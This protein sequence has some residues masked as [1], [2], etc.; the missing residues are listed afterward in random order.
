MVRGHEGLVLTHTPRSQATSQLLAA[1]EIYERKFRLRFETLTLFPKALFAR[2][3]AMAAVPTVPTGP[4]SAVVVASHRDPSVLE[5]MEVLARVANTQQPSE[6]ERSAYLDALLAVY[7]RLP[8]DPRPLLDDPRTLCVGIQR[9]GAHLARVLGRL[10]PGRSS[11]PHAKRIPFEGGLAVGL[12]GLA[13]RQ[14]YAECVITDGAIASGATLMATMDQLRPRVRSFHVFSAHSTWEGLVG[15]GRYA[16]DVGVQL[17]LTVGHATM[18]MN[19]KYYATLAGPEMR[20]AIGDIGDT[21]EGRTRG[22]AS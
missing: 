4:P 8:R 15:L 7:Q 10:A 14:R 21:I 1:A 3:H 22:N 6:A 13:V 16:D 20:L 17:R 2:L 5:H 9:E 11:C 12:Q 18:G 19:E